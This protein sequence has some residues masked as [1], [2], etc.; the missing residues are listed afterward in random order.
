M[1]LRAFLINVIFTSILMFSACRAV[2]NHDVS[3]VNVDF[4]KVNQDNSQVI[5]SA[6]FRE[7]LPYKLKLDSIMGK[8]IATSSCELIKAQPNG[9]LNNFAADA[10]MNQYRKEAGNQAVNVDFCLL[11]YGGLRH[12]LPMGEIKVADVYSLMPFENE[13]VVAVL[14]GSDV[15]KLF[16]YVISSGGQPVSNCLVVGENG[17]FREASIGGKPFDENQEYSIITSDYLANGGDKMNFFLSRV[18]IETTGY[19]IRDLLMSYIASYGDSS[20]LI[21]PDNSSRILN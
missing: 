8:V 11:N 9:N 15:R 19:L 16:E 4:V 3:R 13:A 10:V 5:D 14:K 17:A 1:T 18:K 21:Q 7:I 12:A 6:I 20:L 2:E